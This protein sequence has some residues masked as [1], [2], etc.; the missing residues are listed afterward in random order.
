MSGIIHMLFR[1]SNEGRLNTRAGNLKC[2]LI[3]TL[4][5]TS[6]GSFGLRKQPA[7]PKVEP[8]THVVSI[9]GFRFVPDML[10][11]NVGDTIVWKNEDRVPH[12]A[13]A[14]GKA[15]DSRNIPFGASWEYVA[16]K[17]G[18]YPYTCTPHPNM[19]GKLVVQ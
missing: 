7:L 17:K 3:H 19:R 12:T 5:L 4:L 9:K 2:I 11:V 6:A 16:N 18:T 8:R 1:G 10:T 13:T 15:F 14:E